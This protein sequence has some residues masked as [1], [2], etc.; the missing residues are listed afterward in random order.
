MVEVSEG[1][2]R[3]FLF[4]AH[5][6]IEATAKSLAQK[7]EQEQREKGK[8]KKQEREDKKAAAQ[9]EGEEVVIKAKA[10][11]GKLYAAVGPK[12]V[13]EA[14]KAMG[15][16]IDEDQVEMEPMKET[17]SQEVIINFSSGYE[18]TITVV[19]EV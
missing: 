3:N 6:A 12:Q 11:K 2:A 8:E 13:K 14:L 4:P 9:L 18:A 10:E 17:G 16:K 19:V 7:D 5:L 1:Y 15:H